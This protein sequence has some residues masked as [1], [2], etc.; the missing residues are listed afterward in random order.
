M[1]LYVDIGTQRNKIG[2]F[3]I[4]NTCNQRGTRT[5]YSVVYTMSDGLKIET[6]VWHRRKDGALKLVEL[7]VKAV[8]AA[9]DE[10]YSYPEEIVVK[11]DKME[12]IMC[13][14]I[15]ERFRGPMAKDVPVYTGVLIDGETAMFRSDLDDWLAYKTKGVTLPFD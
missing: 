4:L 12:C 15:P 9:V 1:A 5:L 11:Y 14:D 3:K 6:K 8:Q 2:N 7:V 13:K 10:Y